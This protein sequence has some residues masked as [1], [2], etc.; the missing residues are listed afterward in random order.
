M[1]GSPETHYFLDVNSSLHA[2]TASALLLTWLPYSLCL[3]LL[4]LI[5]KY[6]FI[7]FYA[8]EHFARRYVC[9]SHACLMLKEV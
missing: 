3:L 9:V 7:L 5:N 1:P 6:L 2:Y 8:Q 4:F